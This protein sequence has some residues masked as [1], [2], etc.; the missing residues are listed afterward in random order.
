MALGS[1][2][3][4]ILLSVIETVQNLG[5]PPGE[6][7]PST[8]VG[9]AAFNL[10]VISAIAVVA[11]KGD[12]PKRVYDMG[13]FAITATFSLLAYIWLY[14]VL[15][16]WT[17]DKVTIVEASLTLAFFFV[18]LIFA[19]I[20][21]KINACIKKKKEGPM[22]VTARGGDFEIDDFIEVINAKKVPNHKDEKSK[23][24]HEAI[25]KFFKEHFGDRD[26]DT[27]SREEIEEKLAPSH[28]I[29]ERIKYRHGIGNLIAGRNTNGIELQ[30]NQKYIKEEKVV[31]KKTQEA[32]NKYNLIAGFRCVHYSISEAIG[33]LKIQ[34]LKRLEDED[35]SIGVRTR[36]G[37]AV[38][39]EDF[40]QIDEVL[41]FDKDDISKYVE[42]KILNDDCYEENEDFFV[43]LY[44]PEDPKKETMEGIDSVC[45]VTIIDED[46]P[47]IIGFEKKV[48]MVDPKDGFVV[49]KL[50]RLAGADGEVSVT[51]ET[52]SPQDADSAIAIPGRDYQPVT[53]VA[54]FATGE[55]EKNVVIK[56]L[57]NDQSDEKDDIFQVQLHSPSGGAKLSKKKICIVEIKGDPIEVQ[58][59]KGLEELIKEMQMNKNISWLEQFKQAVILS[60]QL[61]ENGEIDDITY[62]EALLHFLSIGWKVLFAVVPPP[63]LL[64]GWLCFIVALTFIGAV[65][66]IVGEIA[67]LFGCVIGLKQSV[68]AI[69][70][71]ALGTSLPDTFA[72]KTA[73]EQSKH[74]DA[75]IGNITGSNAVNVFLGLGLPWMI[76]SIYYEA[77]DEDF[78]VPAEGL[79]FSVVLF[80][81]CSTTCLIT[82]VIRRFTVKGELG[83]NVIVKWLTCA[84]FVTLWFIYLS[85]S[86]LKSY[87]RLW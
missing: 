8:I 78:G 65:T 9:S 37:T 51:F 6:L 32:M 58:K 30:K 27:L 76:A 87:D 34:V 64:G 45:K 38:Q 13:V 42:V 4:E 84:F 82:L 36:D 7:G 80:L 39:G 31:E 41:H 63:R 5:Q 52:A 86:A 70:F 56:L 83:G 10:L 47:G 46:Q 22:G 59:A 57:E 68:T 55:T 75:A 61:D 62:I 53:G 12:K 66:A 72:S 20:A 69:S 3:P 11:V 19:F 16:V 43:E 15:S 54:T 85:M 23:N 14:I 77:K 24:K 29:S 67:A 81:I 2:A 40:T 79:A 73:A 1:S 26:P 25:Q 74:A 21:D 71:V 48:K 35:I 18:L 28:G 60:P 33:T 44:D 17:P 49:M 50:I